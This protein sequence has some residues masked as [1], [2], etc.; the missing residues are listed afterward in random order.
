MSPGKSDFPLA[1]ARGF[2]NL[3]LA[4]T[5]PG[6]ALIACTSV[7]AAMGLR[8]ALEPVAK[9]YYL[10]MVPAVMITALLAP[11][12]SV[13][14]SIILS[15]V[16]IE[17][18]VRRGGVV[19]TMANGGLFALVGLAVAEACSRLRASRD[20]AETLARNL[21]HRKTL[22]TTIL[23]SM[24]VVTLDDGGRIRRITR[25]AAALLGLEP[26]QAIGRR[27]DDLA[28]GFDATPAEGSAR[29]D[30]ASRLWL[31]ERPGQE[32]V[33][34]T[35]NA[36]KLADDAAP[37]RIVLTL[38]DQS[39][40]E[41][42]RRQERELNDRLSSVWRLNSMGEMAATLAHELNQPLSAAAVYLHA[43]RTDLSRIGPAAEPTVDTLDLAK[44]QLLRAGDIIRRMREMISNGSR[45]FSEERAAQIIRDLEPVIAL[46]GQDTGVA[47]RI[48]TDGADDQVLADRIQLQQALANLIRNAVDAVMDRD[49]GLVTVIGRTLGSEGYEISV[50]DNGPGIAEDQMH[51]IFDP[52]ISTKT[53]G[54]GLGLSV[55]RSIV[56]SHGS[57]LVVSRPQ[58]GGACFTFRL[59]RPTESEA[60]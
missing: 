33:R 27:F 43:G 45:A 4:N 18:T 55:T 17:L 30:E 49:D 29:G 3:R 28:P 15:I 10:P 54:M 24:S 20:A 2:L 25:S 1:G 42:T 13:F 37:E 22:L 5:W 41:A 39:Q 57:A 14:L 7:L 60:P 46:I 19:D 6:G 35:I 21:A 52:M 32:P 50:R 53:G 12:S 36:H 47:I 9:F 23:A 40:A 59:S 8:L 44:A 38:T 11:R 34:L 16:G 31:I 51:R 26:Q 56:E 58:D 48:E